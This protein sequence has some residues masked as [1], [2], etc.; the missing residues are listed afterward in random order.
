M[1][2]LYIFLVLCFFAHPGFAEYYRYLNDNGVIC[3]TDNLANVPVEQRIGTNTYE[4]IKTFKNDKN[5]QDKSSLLFENDSPPKD[6]IEEDET[7]S[8]M[9]QL[10][11]EKGILDNNYEQLVKTKQALKKEKRVF[12]NSVE[13]NAYQKRIRKLNQDISDFETRRQAFE[14]KVRVFNAQTGQ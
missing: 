14:Q 5:N 13:A 6:K 10:N 9:Q 8:T 4:E 7:L 3:F 2:M 12:L 11:K 1:K